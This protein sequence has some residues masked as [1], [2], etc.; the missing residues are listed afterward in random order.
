MFNQMVEDMAHHRLQKNNINWI[1]PL[2]TGLKLAITLRYLATQVTG[3][4][5]L[6]PTPSSLLCQ[7][8][9]CSSLQRYYLSSAASRTFLF[10]WL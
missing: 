10:F 7:N 1:K 5:V 6:A 8:T 2:C 9:W 3:L 4:W